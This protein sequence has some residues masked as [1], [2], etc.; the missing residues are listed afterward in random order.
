MPAAAQ[1]FSRLLQNIAC[2]YRSAVRHERMVQKRFH[3][4]ALQQG[5]NRAGPAAGR[6]PESCSSVNKTWGNLNKF[7]SHSKIKNQA[8]CQD[9]PGCQTD[10][11]SIISIFHLF[12]KLDASQQRNRFFLFVNSGNQ[13]HNPADNHK[14]TPKPSDTRDHA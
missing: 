11:I 12:Q 8:D 14:N 10:Y 4:S 2:I 3:Q 13:S 9:S 1:T 5:K 7:F 6:T